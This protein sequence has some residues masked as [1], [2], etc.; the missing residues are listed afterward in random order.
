MNLT[1][2]LLATARIQYD[3]DLI[4]NSSPNNSKIYQ[5]I[6]SLKQS[7]SIADTVFLDSQI[8]KNDGDKAN[9]FNNFFYSVFTNSNNK[10][11]NDLTCEPDNC[12]SEIDFTEQKVRIYCSYQSESYEGHW[13]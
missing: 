7:E 5:Y 11:N 3:Q 6:R 13:H 2:Q 1:K 4:K 10:A 8:A 12:M 9:L